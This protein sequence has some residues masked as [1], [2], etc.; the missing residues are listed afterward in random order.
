MKKLRITLRL[1]L[2][3]AV[4]LSIVGIYYGYRAKDLISVIALTA[5]LVY[6]V[7]LTLVGIDS[8]KN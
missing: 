3:L 5:S 1:I 2:L 8:I 4:I 6:F 7:P